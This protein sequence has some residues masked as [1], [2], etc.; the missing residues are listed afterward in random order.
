M[1]PHFWWYTAR[2]GGLV[3]WA[4][5][6]ASVVWGLM[7]SGR[8]ARKPKP[9]WML[10]LHRF[11]GGLTVVFVAVHIL[12]IWLDTY[13][14]FGPAELFV[15]LASGWKPGA[16]A[17]GVVALY[18]LIA[19]EVTS[20]LQRRIPRRVWRAVHFSS[21]ALFGFATV[22]ALTAGT[23]SGTTPVLWFAIFSTLLVVN[24]T[25]LRVVGA[26]QPAPVRRPSGPP[27]APAPVG[28]P[29][30]TVAVRRSPDARIPASPHAET[31]EQSRTRTESLRT[32]DRRRPDA[33]SQ[34]GA[35]GSDGYGRSRGS[36]AKG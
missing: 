4:L 22:H 8:L 2:S 7:L 3:A 33:G 31:A 6:T 34:R 1:S 29:T 9:A 36:S 23:D 12:G 10:D 32:R 28:A 14:H 35:R 17:W 25:V 26:R 15:P 24:L 13:V 16:V 30:R 21:F 27:P 11:L 5:A 19:I 20:L 18:L